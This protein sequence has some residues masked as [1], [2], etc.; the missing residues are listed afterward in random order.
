M[1]QSILAQLEER[2]GELPL[3]E[4]KAL[5]D[6][7]ARR[8]NSQADNREELLAQMAADP[9]IQREMREIDQ[10]FAAADADGLNHS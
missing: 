7:L 2:I 8:V 6:R 3:S 4:Q 5:L 1:S 9:D 10:G